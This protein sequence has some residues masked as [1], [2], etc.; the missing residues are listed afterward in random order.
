MTVIRKNP[1]NVAPPIGSYTHLSIVPRES[2]LLVLSGQVG[3]DT[4]GNIPSSVEE[5]VRNALHNIVLILE[6]E[7]VTVEDV[8]KINFW[9]TENLERETFV[10]LWS[11]FHGGKPPATT[12][13]YVSSLVRPELKVEIEA[14]AAR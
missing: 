9:L 10:E 7:G 14:W 4:D 8:I 5:Q 12:I 11:E 6:S 2:E 3:I 13:A 1:A